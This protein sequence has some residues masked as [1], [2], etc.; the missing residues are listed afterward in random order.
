MI[1]LPNMYFEIIFLVESFT[2][3]NTSMWPLL[4]MVSFNVFLKQSFWSV[5]QC[6]QHKV[7]PGTG[8]IHIHV[9]SCMRMNQNVAC[10][11]H[12]ILLGLLNQEG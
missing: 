10:I 6:Q 3:N 12:R 1:H 5:S 2:T 7:H 9:I 11:L 8:I 4:V